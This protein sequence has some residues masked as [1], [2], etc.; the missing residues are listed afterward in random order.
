MGYDKKILIDKEKEV[1]NAES[2]EAEFLKLE[3]ALE[4]EFVEAIKESNKLGAKIN[5]AN[6][7]DY[8]EKYGAIG[9][10]QD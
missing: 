4:A 8:I 3:K 2:K 5:T 10:H 6:V 1:A 9:G 7:L